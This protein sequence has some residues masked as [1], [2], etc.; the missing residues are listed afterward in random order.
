MVAQILNDCEDI[1]AENN[2]SELSV[3]PHDDCAQ[4]GRNPAYLYHFQEKQW[5]EMSCCSL[6]IYFLVVIHSYFHLNVPFLSDVM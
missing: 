1:L 3:K 6:T 4:T 5:I 2:A